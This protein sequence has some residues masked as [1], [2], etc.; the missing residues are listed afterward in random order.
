MAGLI[1]GNPNPVRTKVVGIPVLNVNDGMRSDLNQKLFQV[2]YDWELI[3]DYKDD[4]LLY[5]DFHLG[6]YAKITPELK[7]F[8]ESFKS[9]NAIQLDY[10]YN[11][12][13]IFA[14]SELIGEKIPEYSKVL[15][16]HTGGVQGNEGLRYM[17]KIQ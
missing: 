3:E 5:P 1:L 7:G 9:E 12:K 4:Y 16:I 17:G 11:G 2:L 14:L 15:A 8:V 6:G 10:I 13:M